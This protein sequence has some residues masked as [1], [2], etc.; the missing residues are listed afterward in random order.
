MAFTLS[1]FRTAW[2]LIVLTAGSAVHAQNPDPVVLSPSQTIDGRSQA[3]WSI[4]RFFPL[5]N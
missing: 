5:V 1:Y 4:R 3:D 2:L